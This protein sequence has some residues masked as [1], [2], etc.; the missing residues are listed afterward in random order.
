MNALESSLLTPDT[1]LVFGAG[2][3][4][5][6]VADAAVSSGSWGRVIA[7]DQNR[8]VCCGRL[9]P[10]VELVQMEAVLSSDFALH[11]A[12]G[13]NLSREREATLKGL[14]RLVS[15]RHSA[16][17]VSRASQISAGCFLAANSVIAPGVVLGIG[18]IVNHGAVADHD[19]QT[20]AFCHIAPN[21]T[22]GG[23][24][25]IGNR[26]MIGA[27]AVV[28]PSVCITDDVVVGAGAV[29][30]TDIIQPGT[31][32]GIPARRIS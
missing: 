11:V 28:L 5:R 16:A 4:G 6:V 31:Y 25:R 13:S 18:V 12:I 9:L 21:A 14:D 17:V 27:A 10:G 24:V 20:G 29:V 22:L 7:S 23:A 3:H 26:V 30:T 2:G 19:V 32:A 1:L 15:I 8:A